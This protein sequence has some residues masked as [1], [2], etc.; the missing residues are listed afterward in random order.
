[1]LDHRRQRVTALDEGR[2]NLASTFEQH[3]A[4]L[5]GA[6]FKHCIELGGTGVERFDAHLEFADQ[7]LAAFNQGTLYALQACLELGIDL[8]RGV[9][10][11]RNHARGAVV[12]RL[13]QHSATFI[14]AIDER[15]ARIGD[16]HRYL[17]RGIQDVVADDVASRAELVA[18]HTMC[19]RN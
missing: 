19:A 11:Q 5:V 18:Q 17:G 12:D 15:V 8:L 1:M 9:A 13:E 7:H 3:L 10:Y 16:R 2:G 6:I 14:D 4:D